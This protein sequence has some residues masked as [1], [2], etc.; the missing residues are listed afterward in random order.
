MQAAVE[1]S[2]KL[3]RS[4]HSTVII[5]SPGCASFDMFVNR[6]DRVHQF[7]YHMRNHIT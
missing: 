6:E 2:I 1:E 3:A 5:F 7:L 4:L